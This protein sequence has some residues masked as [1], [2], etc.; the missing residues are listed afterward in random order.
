LT[1]AP[2][3]HPDM[4]QPLLVMILGFYCFY[5]VALFLFTRAEI[6][7]RERNSTWVKELVI[8]AQH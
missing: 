3:M 4:F 8:G 1:S 7:R 5:T 2:S 6:L